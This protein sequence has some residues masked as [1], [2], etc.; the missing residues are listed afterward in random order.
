MKHEDH[1][2]WPEPEV[3]H[4]EQALDRTFSGEVAPRKRKRRKPTWK[5]FLR[6]LGRAL[7]KILIWLAVLAV[8]G[9]IVGTAVYMVGTETPYDQVFDVLGVF[10]RN[11]FA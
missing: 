9:L 6:G 3:V 2:L 11:L 4:E 7:L 5:G 1:D 8:L 10:F